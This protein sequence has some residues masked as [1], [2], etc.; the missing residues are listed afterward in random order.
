M[1][2]EFINKLRA[3]G[4][5][6]S[7][8]QTWCDAVKADLTS[9]ATKVF[10]HGGIVGSMPDGAAVTGANSG[11]TGT[12]CHATS[13]QVLIKTIS[14]T[15]QSG[16]QVYKDA[17]TNYVTISSAG[18]SAICVLECFNDTDRGILSNV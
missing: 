6:Y 8:I 5:D 17:G 11:A 2:T 3:S 18:D 15:F 14:G 16:E 13:G 9:A 10:S 1:A 7:L 12:L 4:D